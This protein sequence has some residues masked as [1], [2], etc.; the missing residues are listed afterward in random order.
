[1]FKAHRVESI[2]C[3]TA[4]SHQVTGIENNL[5]REAKF[6]F[7]C[8]LFFEKIQ[9]PLWLISRENRCRPVF[10]GGG[11]NVKSPSPRVDSKPS[12]VPHFAITTGTA[13]FHPRH[14]ARTS[15]TLL[16]LLCPRVYSSFA[17]RRSESR[18]HALVVPCLPRNI[19][20][21]YKYAKREFIPLHIRR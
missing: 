2:P 6:S 3:S 5:P 12:P 13:V 7:H 11:H 18:S 1:M 19:D 21:F 14:V 15:I 4:K 8:G 9:F 10:S 16:R 20:D 17:G